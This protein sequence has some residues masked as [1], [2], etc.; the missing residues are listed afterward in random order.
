MSV[1][2]GCLS[3]SIKSTIPRPSLLQA[4]SDDSRLVLNYYNNYNSLFHAV[5]MLLA[6]GYC[7]LKEPF[8]SNRLMTSRELWT[9]RISLAYYI[10]DTAAGIYY[11]YNDFWMSLHHV[12]IFLAYY[13][14]LRYSSIASEMFVTM[15]VGEISNP[16]LI[17][18]K[19]SQY[20]GQTQK[21]ILLG[22]GF[23]ITYLM[24]RT[25]PAYKLAKRVCLSD[26]EIVIKVSCTSMLCVSFY[27]IFEIFVQ[28]SMRAATLLGLTSAR[29]L[30]S[31]QARV[32][33]L[34]G[35]LLL[36]GRLFVKGTLLEQRFP[37]YTAKGRKWSI[38]E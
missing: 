30:F 2:W 15:F 16:F 21:S 19:T 9:I 25:Y 31:E 22:A 7:L 17:L 32:C 4:E 13:H 23:I 5:F 35:C 27:W 14:S 6:C 24:L 34:A 3:F 37:A 8:E 10:F 1:L 26:A 12:L 20:E 28:I 11:M 18:M 38:F 33:W 29:E 36:C